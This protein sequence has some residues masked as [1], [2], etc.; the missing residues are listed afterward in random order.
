MRRRSTAIPTA[1]ATALLAGVLAPGASSATTLVQGTTSVTHDSRVKAGLTFGKQVEPKMRVVFREPRIRC[2]SGENSASR[3]QLVMTRPDFGDQVSVGTEADCVAGIATYFT[4]IQLLG[5]APKK[6]QDI[7]PGSQIQMDL[8]YDGY[9]PVGG[10]IV[11]CNH[12]QY[13]GS[14]DFS[15]PHAVGFSTAAMT[16]HTVG[17]GSGQAP[18]AN[19]GTV[20]FTTATFD[21]QPVGAADP[22][23]WRMTGSAGSVLAVCSPV[24]PN[25]HFAISWR[26]AS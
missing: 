25:G 12:G 26:G 15:G 14:W 22:V 11:H 19:F 21:D 13:C 9:A 8:W 4:W 7:Q 3:I 18:L 1:V 10:Y 17:S 20:Y 5:E 6:G 24:H 16:V 23:V 2:A